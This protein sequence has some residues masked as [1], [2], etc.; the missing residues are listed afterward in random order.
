MTGKQLKSHYAQSLFFLGWN[1]EDT[2]ESVSSVRKLFGG[3]EGSRTRRRP[4]HW[5]WLVAGAL[6]F[7]LC[8]QRLGTTWKRSGT[9]GKTQTDRTS[10]FPARVDSIHQLLTSFFRVSFLVFSLF[11][12]L[13]ICPPGPQTSLSA[14]GHANFRSWILRAAVRSS[15]T[16]SPQKMVRQN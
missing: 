2:C 7:V 11:F 5:K 10:P 8:I 16:K 12:L 4:P 15:K 14:E 1:P 6:G 3:S 13:S 9:S